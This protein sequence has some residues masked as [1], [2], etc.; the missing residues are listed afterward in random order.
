MI[1]E[2][3]FQ[4]PWLLVLLGLLPVYALLRGK[5]GKFSALSFSSA[6]IARAAGAQA[7]SA[8]GRFLAFLRLLVVAL[9]IVALAGPRLAN[10]HVE[11]ET[12]GIDIML[13][14]DLSWSMMATDMGKPEERMSR[15]AGASGVLKDF[16]AKRPND[17]IGLIAFSGVPYLV[18]P[19]TLNHAWLN[20][21]LERLH[22]GIIG[23]LGTAIGDAVVVG[24]KRLK[25]VPN[26]KS[27]VMI[28]LTDGDNNMGKIDPLPAAQLAAA[29]GV[30]IY[31]IGIGI[32]A[33]CNMPAFDPATGQFKLDANGNL[34][35]TLLLQPANYSVLGKMADLSGG[36]FYRATNQRELQ[37]IY[38][39]I[40]R[41]E[42]SEVKQRRFAT[43][44]P[45]FHWP[46]LAALGLLAL[47]LILAE[48]RYRRVP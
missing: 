11:T 30:R 24:A 4:F 34:I 10:Y 41:L 48:T 39:Q 7:R 22:I 40:D 35:P 13:V 26:S 47:E 31:T 16:I 29:L 37:N 32:E 21:N 45:L 9:G 42:K 5:V 2:F 46:L 27:R 18:S 44:E 19:L 28:L 17:R 43:Y 12:P 23:D 36:H 1:G 20:E 33:P 3:E 38:N 15:Y 8:A 6:D 25:A 14:L